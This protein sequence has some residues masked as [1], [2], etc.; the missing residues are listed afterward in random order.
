MDATVNGDNLIFSWL[1]SSNA[2]KYP[3]SL[4]F[5]IRFGCLEDD[6]NSAFYYCINL[7]SI[8]FEGTPVSIG[9]SA[10]SNCTKLTAINVPL[11]EG[12]VENA[13]WGATNAIINYNYVA[14]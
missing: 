4:N 14:G 9:S 12:A 13:P 8:T 5:L 7:T 1:V 3:G 6:Y 11:A 10:F 2:T